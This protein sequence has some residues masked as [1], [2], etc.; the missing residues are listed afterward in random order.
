MKL[1]V[2]YDVPEKYD[3]HRTKIAQILKNYGLKRIEY[4]VFFGNSTINL[5]E[6]IAMRLESIVKKIQADIRMFPICKNCL[7]KSLVVKENNIFNFEEM[8]SSVDF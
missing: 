7:E 6:T 8:K 4:S 1:L 3:D 5:M 2:I